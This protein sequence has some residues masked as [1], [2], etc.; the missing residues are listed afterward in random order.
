MKLTEETILKLLRNKANRPMKVS[1][2]VKQFSIPDGQRREIRSRLKEMAAD[3]RLIK[4]RGGRYGLPDEMNL[5]SGILNT[6]PRGFGFV[7][8]DKD[9]GEKDIFISRGHMGDAMHQDLVTVRMEPGRDWERPEGRVI[10]ILKRNTKELVGTYEQFGRDGWV[11]PMDTKYLHDVFISAKNSKGAKTGHVVSVAIESYPAKHQPPVGRIAEVLGFSD[12]PEVEVKAILRKFGI[13]PEF[14]PKVLSTAEKM[15]NTAAI[16]EQTEER[17]D[18]SGELIFTIDGKKAK[19]FDDAVSIEKMG[20]GFRLGVHIADVSHFVREGSPL[21][22]EAFQRGTSIYYPDSVVPMLPFQLSNEICSLK[23][24]EKRLALSVSI[25]FD[26]QGNV[27]GSKIFNS[28]IASKIRFTYTEVARLLEKGDPEN[29]TEDVLNALK[30]MHGLSRILRKNR[31]RRGSVDFNLPEPEVQMDDKGRI[32]RIVMAEHNVAHELIEEFMLAANQVVAK[33]LSDKNAPAIHRIHE[34]PDDDKIAEF[35]RFILSFGVKLKNTHNV[36]SSDLQNLLKQVKNHPEERTINTLLL[37][38]MK[39]AVYSAKDPGHYCLGFKYYTHFTSPI[40][41]YPDLI[42]HR[43]VKSFLNKRKCSQREHKRLLPKVAEVAE[44]SS[45]REQ[46]AMAIEREVNDLRR[47]QF[48]ADKIG[49]IYSGLITSVTAFGFFVELQEVFVEGLVKISSIQDDYYIFIESEH[50]W[51]G[52]RR[53]R[54]FK[55]GDTVKIKVAS[56]DIAKRQIDLTLH[57]K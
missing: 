47:A 45:A 56:V 27:V 48:M 3:G 18:L 32:E 19:D 36:P 51:Q 37:R 43:L 34:P 57:P 11:I 41:R 42:T 26:A 9:S 12:D 31:F 8:Q 15:A 53:H 38:T 16:E 5:V 4:V 20:D 28:T 2:L 21:D 55:I 14:P 52:Q 54:A 22:K 29:R 50:K 35:N 39:K 40:R 10:R 13:T 24:N 25:D 1:E 44:Q 30:T 23:P 6:N 46:N 33:F 7:A 17:T 49:K